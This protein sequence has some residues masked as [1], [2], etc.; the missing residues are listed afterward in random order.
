MPPETEALRQMASGLDYIHSK[1]VV[2]R[3]IKPENVLI[4]F[5]FILKISD[6]GCCKPMPSDGCLSVTSG[7]QGTRVYY[8]PEYLRLEGNKITAEDRKKITADKSIDTFSLGCLFFTYIIKEG[9][10][11]H[12]FATPGKKFYSRETY[13]SDVTDNILNGR[14]FLNENG[15]YYCSSVRI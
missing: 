15:K 13:A 2:H 8:A 1:N 10:F 4:S 14:K 9:P 11:I 5:S 6:F 7:P 12:L 3:D